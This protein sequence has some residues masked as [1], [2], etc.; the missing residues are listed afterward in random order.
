MMLDTSLLRNIRTIV[1]HDSCADG[2][3]SAI[4][5][6]DAF[7][8]AE[9][10][11]VQYGTKAYLELPAMEGII[12]CDIAPPAHRVKEFVDS[13][14][15]VLDHHKTAKSVIE[16]FGERGIYS[17]ESIDPGV[18]GTVLA[19]R[20]VW[21]PLREASYSPTI[22]NWAL[23]F[24]TLCGVPDTWQRNHPEWQKSS[25]LNH[26]LFFMSNT[27]WMKVSL[28]WL[29]TEWDRTYDWIG[30]VLSTKHS[31]A[32]LK[33]IKKAGRYSSDRGT[34]ILMMNST[35][36]T[37]D[38]SELLG[39]EFDLIVGFGYDVEEGVE[40]LILSTRTFGDYDCA[41]F[42][43][44]LGGGGHTKAAG[45]SVLVND[46]ESPYK[47]ILRVVNQFESNG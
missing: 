30:A 7:P 6:K 25:E 3:G 1:A 12:F 29:A 47:T 5:L 21:K 15:I 16:Q 37:S 24:S 23:R 32:V 46:Q 22:Q 2:T 34:R 20:H 31:K 38:A 39:K 35:S 40:R 18:S 43:K 19:Y 36:H 11:F 9:V 33:S 26:L 17:D 14:A 27:E 10:V 45:C 41:A 4:F 13:G 28:H 42:A 44:S 8:G